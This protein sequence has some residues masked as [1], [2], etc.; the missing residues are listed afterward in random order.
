MGKKDLEN[1][2][3]KFIGD[4]EKRI[5][6]DFLRIIR[7]IRFSVQYNYQKFEPS[8]L[9]AIKLNLTGIHKISKERVLTELIKILK[10]QNFNMISTNNELKT[11]FNLIFPE[12]KYLD[13][14]KKINKVNSKINME[15]DILLAILLTDNSKNHE[16]FCHKYSPSKYIKEKL[17]FINKNI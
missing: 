16:Y 5:Q 9:K 10:L 1:K 7:F 4:P 2:I 15:T 17:N 11:I 3:I 13:R 6:E 14:L 12:L 8:T